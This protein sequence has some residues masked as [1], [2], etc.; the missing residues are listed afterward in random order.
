MTMAGCARSG[1]T[2]PEAPVDLTVPDSPKPEPVHQDP[3]ATPLTGTRDLGGDFP[4]G[5]RCAM[6]HSNVDS[7]TA[8]RDSQGAPIAPHDLWQGTMM[9]NAARDPIFRAQLASEM[10]RAPLAAPAIEKLC[11]S[12]H[13][14]AMAHDLDARGK[15]G[16]RLQDLSGDDDDAVRGLDSVN[17]I[18]CHRIAPDGLGDESTFDGRYAL[19]PPGVIYGPYATPFTRPME[20]H[21][22][23][24][25]TEGGHVRDAAMCGSCHTLITH[26]I[27][28]DGTGTGVTFG[29]QTPFLDYRA[30]AYPAEG[31]TCQTC[32]MPSWDPSGG[33]ISTRIARR[34][35]G[36]DFPPIGPR[37]PYARH[38]F[39]G[40]NTLVPAMLRDESILGASAPDA[41]FNAT[42][43][44]AR[45]SLANAATLAL[46]PLVAEASG[47]SVAITIG[48]R[49]GHKLPAGYPARRM[50]LHVRVLDASG[51]VMLE[52][53]R[54]NAQGVIV[55]AAGNALSSE[56][57]AASP[58]PHHD[59]IS[60]GNHAQ[61]WEQV[62]GD[63]NGVAT[64]VLLAAQTMVKDNRVLPRGFRAT[65]DDGRRVAPVGVDGD[66]NFVGGA[67]RVTVQ[68]AV[69]PA[70]VEV[71]LLYQTLGA[72]WRAALAEADT[73]WGNALA[74]MLTRTPRATEVMATANATY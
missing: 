49:T 19:S 73:S 8:M 67:D 66:P 47:Y 42:I 33:E 57:P 59:V 61:V 10:K 54:V 65:S 41:A 34:P 13:A 63:A 3:P 44:A 39:A 64:T 46:G 40:A 69:R 60:T 72:R 4:T 71:A 1:A 5:M 12:C 68:L 2:P 6:C 30:S 35:N 17:C 29:E 22:G 32:H 23:Y 15:D 37:S 51:E 48:S 70:R 45:A 20:M 16:P 7:S 62:P 24:T 56:L 28:P 18:S 36:G 55:D 52:S 11:L 21:T 27:T 9:A 14:P 53:G 25:P 26:A 38:V 50:I 58:E 43:A 74:E 31:I